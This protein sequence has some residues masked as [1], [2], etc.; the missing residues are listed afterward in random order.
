MFDWRFPFGTA[1]SPSRPRMHGVDRGE[2]LDT[3]ILAEVHEPA[4]FHAT[5]LGA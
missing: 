4:L 3:A 5:G 1:S 2:S